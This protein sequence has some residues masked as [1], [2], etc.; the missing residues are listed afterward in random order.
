M[1]EAPQ[2][3]A[4]REDEGLRRAEEDEARIPPCAARAQDLAHGVARPGGHRAST[5]DRSRVDRRPLHRG[6]G[7]LPG[8]RREGISRL[9]KVTRWRGARVLAPWQG[10]SRRAAGRDLRVRWDAFRLRREP[11][12]LPVSLRARMG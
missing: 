2:R 1:G 7:A 10:R 8:A 11:R 9:W 3:Q 12:W 5:E 6:H 4:A